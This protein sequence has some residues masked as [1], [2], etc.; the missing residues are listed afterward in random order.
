MRE[1]SDSVDG[2]SLACRALEIPVV[3]GNVSL[4]NSTDGVSIY[5]TPMIGVV[6][7]VKDVRRATPAILEQS[8]NLWFLGPK[9]ASPTLAA[10]LV[11]K[12][13]DVDPTI[14]KINEI[15]WEQEKNAFLVLD[16][17]REEGLIDAVRPVGQG[18]PGLTAIKM[19][20][21]SKNSA[22]KSQDITWVGT[23]VPFFEELPASYLI[24]FSRDAKEI[25]SSLKALADSKD[26]VIAQ[27]L[28]C[29]NHVNASAH[30]KLQLPFGRFDLVD[31]EN[32]WNSAHSM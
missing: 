18:G 11:A 7:K 28:S 4:Y 13:M 15:L 22:I 6:G 20:L 31:L 10:S 17:W 27:V 16:Q 25:Y 8:A 19:L 30:G 3:S 29:A 2:I 12:L 14:G 26:L 21:G 5:P 32:T 23:M 24:E 1:F 9:S